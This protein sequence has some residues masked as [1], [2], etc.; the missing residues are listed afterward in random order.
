MPHAL[1][2]KEEYSVQVKEIDD[3]HKIF[4]GLIF[5]LF[6]AMNEK[7]TK[8]KLD[9]ILSEL[10]EYADYHFTVEEKY[11]IEFNYENKDEHITQHQGITKKVTD[12][13]KR[14]SNNEVD[15]S[16]ELIDFME[17]WLIGHVMDSDQKYVKC[18]KENG[19]K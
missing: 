18:F 4:F 5:K 13:R 19:L 8:E 9:G 16:F 7:K 6:T 1:E 12:I 17:D 11:F 3:Q 15:I 2:W 14:Y 10:I